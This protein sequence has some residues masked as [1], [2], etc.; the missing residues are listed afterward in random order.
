M[1]WGLGVYGLGGT[2][3]GFRGDLGFGVYSFV[4]GTIT[5]GGALWTSL[6]Q[7]P[8]ESSSLSFQ[9]IVFV[10]RKT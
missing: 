4:L 6:F 5:P 3:L 7:A 1:V 8:T 9:G 2:R 10:S